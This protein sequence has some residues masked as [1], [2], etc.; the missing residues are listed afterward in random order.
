VIKIGFE[1]GFSARFTFSMYME[2]VSRRGAAFSIPFKIGS[3]L[4]V[5]M[6]KS[7]IQDFVKW[8]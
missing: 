8:R 1:C 5:Q 7:Q 2:F 6:K 3:D 4:E